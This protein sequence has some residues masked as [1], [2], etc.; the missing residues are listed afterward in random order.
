MKG[1]VPS[2]ME[3]KSNKLAGGAGDW[4]P[5]GVSD[6]DSYQAD[7]WSESDVFLSS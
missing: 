1:G 7:H 6:N 4:R 3:I 5:D 2:I